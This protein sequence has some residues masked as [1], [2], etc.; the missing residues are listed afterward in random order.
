MNPPRL[1]TLLVIA[2]FALNPTLGARAEGKPPPSSA[3]PPDAPPPGLTPSKTTLADV[4]A[5]WRI[6][7]GTEKTKAVT[8][9]EVDTIDAFGLTGSDRTVTAGDD[10]RDTYTLG[11]VTTES[12]RYHGQ[13]WRLNENGIVVLEVGVHKKNQV[14]SQALRDAMSAP[15]AGVTLVGEVTEPVPAYVLKVNPPDGRLEWLYI[16]EKTG[17]LDRKDA[18]Y[19]DQRVTTTY[20]DYHAVNGLMEAWHTHVSDGWAANDTDIRVVSDDVGVPVANDQLKIPDGRAPILDFPPNVKSVVLPARVDDG[21]VIVRVTING[22]GLDFILDSGAGGILLDSEVAKEL[23]IATFGKS[24]QQTMGAYESTQA[25]IPKMAVGPISLT[26]TYVECVPFAQQRGFATKIV[27]LLGFDF[28]AN[29]AVRIDYD[30]GTVTASTPDSFVPPTNGIEV[31]VV[32]DDGVPF[33]QAQ[34]GASVGDHFI[35][36]TGSTDVLVFSA[37]A[38]AHPKDV[39]DEGLGRSISSYLPYISASGVGGDI[40]MFPTQVSSYHFGAVNFTDFLLMR[41]AAGSAF[42]FEDTDGLVGFDVLR[43]FKVT[44]DYKD[45]EVYL[46]PGSFLQSQKAPPTPTP[47]PQAT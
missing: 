38:D 42:E 12:G 22:R 27:G 7:H 35:L 32:L 4:F 2:L 24:V 34:V 30:T 17:L 25:I 33:V 40:S 37:F 43:F 21:A 18:A 14:D 5:K 31:P 41:T 36:D 26:N 39:T 13:R 1:A 16:D 23:G 47:H 10:Y 46:E 28:I 9:V 8:E 19:P 44:F 20:D 11:P 3:L 6:A 29:A 15:T 45:G